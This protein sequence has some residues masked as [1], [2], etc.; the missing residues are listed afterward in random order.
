MK[1]VLLASFVPSLV[2]AMMGSVGS[3]WGAIQSFTIDNLL[4]DSCDIYVNGA[5]TSTVAPV[6]RTPEIAVGPA[7]VPGRTNILLRCSDGGVY[8]TSV[9][10]NWT[11]CDF[12]VDEEGPGLTTVPGSCSL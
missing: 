4:D 7:L 2:I 11:R 5:F 10:A 12:T 9:E 8:G 1:R 3:A 6:S